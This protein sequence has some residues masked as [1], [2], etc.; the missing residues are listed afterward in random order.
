LPLCTR[1]ELV[2]VLFTIKPTPAR[3]VIHPDFSEMNTVVELQYTLQWQDA[4]LWR[5]PC[6][7]ALQQM[8]SLGV[9]AGRSD[10]ARYAKQ[11]IRDRFF[12]FRLNAEDVAPGF[13]L[14][15]Q[16][17]TFVG[18]TQTTWMHGYNPIMGSTATNT[19]SPECTHCITRTAQLELEVLQKRF[20]FFYYPFDT[21]KLRI[22]FAVQGANLFTCDMTDSTESNLAVLRPLFPLNLTSEGE[23]KLLPFTRQWLL[24][25]SPKQ[26]ITLQHPVVDGNIRYDMC[27]LQVIIKRNSISFLVKA[28][29]VTILTVFVSM[30]TAANL[31]PE[32]QMGDRFAVLFIAFLVLAVNFSLDLG[33]G[34]V[35]QLMW[36]DVFNLVQLIL[37]LVSVFEAVLVNHL[38]KKQCDRLAT[39]VDKVMKWTLPYLLYPALTLGSLLESAEQNVLCPS[40]ELCG[41]SRNDPRFSQRGRITGRMTMQEFGIFVNTVG[42]FLTV[43]LSAG[44]IWRRLAAVSMEQKAS[45][46][47]LIELCRELAQTDVGAEDESRSRFQMATERVFNAFDLDGS[48]EIDARELRA[49]MTQMYPNAHGKLL[50]DLIAEKRAFGDK[51]LD[52]A[53]IQDAIA[54]MMD[55]MEK[56]LHQGNESARLRPVEQDPAWH[57]HLDKAIGSNISRFLP[58]AMKKSCPRI[59]RAVSR[60]G[61]MRTVSFVG[62]SA[63]VKSK[64]TR[65]GSREKLRTGIVA[66][67]ESSTST[68]DVESSGERKRMTHQKEDAHAPDTPF[69]SAA[70]SVVVLRT[71]GGCFLIGESSTSNLPEGVADVPLDGLAAVAVAK[72]A[73]HGFSISFQ[74]AVGETGDEVVLYLMRPASDAAQSTHG[75][76]ETTMNRE[77][78]EKGKY[79]LSAGAAESAIYAEMRKEGSGRTKSLRRRKREDKQARRREDDGSSHESC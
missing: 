16:W 63:R 46:D 79:E 70:P 59:S 57:E 13:D 64:Q 23:A 47:H 30:V 55:F 41:M 3:L 45:I 6:F 12:D 32:D 24:A 5:H 61:S 76:V 78:V 67:Q 17:A 75:Q 37:V 29:F 18:S 11:R 1:Y 4:R 39:C 71:T 26:A 35:S 77:A 56:K 25:G 42:I 50:R 43:V 31:H 28:L 36:V 65:Q 60:A 53:T 73:A 9:E 51:D 44:M 14:Y 54:T 20:D 38:Y 69:D 10:N 52:S 72:L 2:P 19:T 74:S 49:I 33:L 66:G 21:Q 68:V 58:A 34:I 7:G 22:R 15:D 62:L 8:L 40:S 48:G 27:D